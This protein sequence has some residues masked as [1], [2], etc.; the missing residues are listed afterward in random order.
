MKPKHISFIQSYS[1]E[2]TLRRRPGDLERVKL[3]N[4]NNYSSQL[5]V[6][7]INPCRGRGL[8]SHLSPHLRPFPRVHNS[9]LSSPEPGLASAC[10]H[11]HAVLTHEPLC[12]QVQRTDLWCQCP[13]LKWAFFLRAK[14]HPT[15]LKFAYTGTGWWLGF[16]PMTRQHEASIS[17]WEACTSPSAYCVQIL[18]RRLHTGTRLSCC[19]F[20]GIRT[21]RCFYI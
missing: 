11:C 9:Q 6:R 8:G 19:H 2:I 20:V 3:I 10:K 14:S 12:D 7:L 21:W 15:E 17:Q 1:S 18:H 5:N 16:W 13:A 4:V